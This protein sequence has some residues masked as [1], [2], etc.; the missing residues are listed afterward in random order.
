[1]HFSWLKKNGM[2]HLFIKIILFIIRL[3]QVSLADFFLI[4][5]L[6]DDEGV[7]GSLLEIT[8]I[9]RYREEIYRE[10]RQTFLV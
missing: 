4:S 8:S 5:K 1:M 7:V 9:N 10:P 2:I 3:F 6:I